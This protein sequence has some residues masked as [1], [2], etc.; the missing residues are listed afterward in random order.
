MT[1]NIPPDEISVPTCPHCGCVVTPDENI[2]ICEDC[3]CEAVEDCCI[4]DGLCDDCADD[5]AFL[6]MEDVE[7]DDED[8]EF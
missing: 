7:F 8:D 2:L 6:E 1:Q 5:R 4:H 3:G